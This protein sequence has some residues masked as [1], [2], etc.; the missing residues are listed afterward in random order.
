MYKNIT[1]V[2]Q[3]TNEIK[4]INNFIHNH[5][6]KNK[7]FR[8]KFNKRSTKFISENYK[9]LLKEIKVLN[10]WENIQC[11]LIGR[12]NVVKMAV[13]PKLIYK[14][15]ATSIRIP[16]NFFIEIDK[17]ILKFIWNCKGLE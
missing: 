1:C 7:I 15:N 4:K 11:S 3:F 16:A 2:G 8:Y 9:V 17:M 5:I 13:C 12:P 6:K 10:K 14:F